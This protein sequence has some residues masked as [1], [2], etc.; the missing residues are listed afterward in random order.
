MERALLNTGGIAEKLQCGAAEVLLKPD[1]HN[2]ERPSAETVEAFLREISSRFN[3]R[4]S[5]NKQVCLQHGNTLTWG[6][7]QPPDLVAFPT[8]TKDV[9]ELVRC[10]AGHGIPTIAFGAG[11]SLEG[12]LNAPS[13]GVSIDFS[14][15][16]RIV[17]VN[18]SDLDC[19][20]EA[21]VT[22]GELNSYLRDLGL[23][24]PIDPGA[25]ASIGGMVATRASGTNAV[26][27][28]TMRDA[29][30]SLTVVMA[31]G[32]IV[33]TASRARKSAAGYDLTRLMVGSEGTLGI[34]T[35]ISLRL[36]GIPEA[37]ASGFSLF[38][39]VKHACEAAITAI[40]Y[41]IPVARVELLDEMQVR[42]CNLFSKLHLPEQPLLLL[43]FHG[44]EEGVRE[45]AERFEEIASE[46]GGSSFSW[47]TKEEERQK[48]WQA[49]HDSHWASKGLRPGS[50]SVVTDVCVPISRLA[51]CVEETKADLCA[52]AITAT[53]VGHVGDG[54]FH[55]QLLIDEKSSTEVA[56]CEEFLHKLI[57]R[58]IAMGGTS[59][60]EHGVGQMK[61][62]Y[63]VQEHGEATIEVMRAIK[64][65]LDPLGIMNPGKMIP[66]R[67]LLP[68]GPGPWA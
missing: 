57:E 54:N 42:A 40:Q 32:S 34:I 37:T 61:R 28:G 35:E 36:H 59:T 44:T 13:G 39:T 31:D 58:A 30:L 10:A 33:R 14:E 25:D 64:A 51:E 6:H 24:F 46:C 55:V 23:F 56:A 4:I 27:Y 29:V 17:A 63:M 67:P 12:Q 62:Q 26:R 66:D 11:T 65:A 18:E 1:H 15:M 60:G 9:A 47:A 68:G 7:N 43:E 20:V 21:G 5:S 38:P 8:S 49:R 22:R 3:G 53:I 2:L 52:R 16:K 41:G 45:Q 50:Y 48:I 19:T